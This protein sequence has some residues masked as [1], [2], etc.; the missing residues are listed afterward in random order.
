TLI[1]TRHFDRFVAAHLPQAELFQGVTGQCLRSLQE[2]KSR[3]CRTIVDSVTNHID[4]FVQHQRRECAR[5]GIRPS[6]G[7]SMRRRM[8]REYEQADLIRVMS[9]G[10]AMTFISRGIASEKVV[11]AWP[12]MHIE[13]FPQ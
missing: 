8:L 3:G 10:A 6:I 12:I 4:D 13:E 7:E 1:S 2:A 9:D 11:V 5:F